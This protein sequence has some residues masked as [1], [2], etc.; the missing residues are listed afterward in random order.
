MAKQKEV[1]YKKTMK[2]LLANLK[3][4][5]SLILLV[6]LLALFPFLASWSQS[7]ST[8]N[9]LKTKAQEISTLTNSI[10]S[11]YAENIV[12]RIIQ[13]E[14]EAKLSERYRD[15]H[16][17]IPIPATF[18]IEMG[19]ILDGSILNK[20]V[21]YRFISDYPFKTRTP[22]KLDKF[23][24]TSLVQFRSDPL[25]T[26]L[27][28]FEGNLLIPSQYRLTTPIVMKSSCIQCHN[29]HPGST[30]TDWKVGDVRGIQE[31]I[32]R[33][34]P[35]ASLSR[36]WI[37]TTGYTA[38]LASLGYYNLL[39][40]KKIN[41]TRKNQL[42]RLRIRLESERRASELAS[43]RVAE[44]KIYKNA[45]ENSIVG[46][47]ICDMTLPDCPT[48]YVNDAFTKITGYNKD[49]A[50]G[51]N[52]RYLQGPKTNP[53]EIARIRECIRAGKPYSGT[54]L[55][56][57]SDGSIFVNNLTLTPIRNENNTKI[58]YYLANQIESKA[59]NEV[60]TYA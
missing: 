1:G 12:A 54:L 30:K 18:S 26:Q 47:T 3:A 28:E 33:S 24:K 15:I 17:G 2:E 14:G 60:N 13:A 8:A 39:K 31:I 51:K 16:G 4:N 20:R 6:I 55:N 5:I 21:A 49:F 41:D 58:K 53:K 45:I 44:S 40:Y 59:S 37:I 23:E 27:T 11:Y 32:V 10:R 19:R 56:Y 46:V 42:D 34:S 52:C 57:K 9:D 48:I 50:I 43:R 35:L 38:I 36:G 25:K 7:T 22:H 29:A